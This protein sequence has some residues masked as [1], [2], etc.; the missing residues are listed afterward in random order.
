MTAIKKEELEA[1]WNRHGVE[2][3]CHVA[4]WHVARKR[5]FVR[6]RKV[7]EVGQLYAKRGRILSPLKKR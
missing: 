3:P 2:M 7:V 4:T 6:Y 1:L 5:I